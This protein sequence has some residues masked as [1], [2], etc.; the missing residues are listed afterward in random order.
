MVCQVCGAENR[1]DRRFCRECGVSLIAG[2]PS[3]GTVNEPDDR[4][5]GSC[6]TALTGAP[7]TPRPV[8]LQ[9][10][11]TTPRGQGAPIAERRLVTVLFAD[12]VGFTTLAEGRDP[13][14]TRDLLGRYFDLARD[15]AERYGGTVEKFIGDAVMAVWGAPVA[16]ENDPE[17]AVRAALDLLAAIPGLGPGIRAR[18]GLMTG[19]AAV[20][21][22]AIGQGMVAGELVNTAARL[23]AAAAPGEVLV[24]EATMQAAAAAVAFEAAGEQTLKGIAAPVQAWIARRVVAEVGGRNRSEGLEAPFVGRD[25]EIRMLK[26]L[27][28]ATARDGR[29]RLVSVIG[30]AGIGKSRLAWE[31]GKYMD[32]LLQ[33]M[34]WHTGRSPAYGEG[35]TFWALGEM[36]RSRCRL[37]ET[38]DE[39]TTRSKVS[40][41]V[42]R[43]VPDDA[44]RR[45]VTS[46]LLAL[47]GVEEH[48]DDADQLFAAWCAF[49]EHMAAS[50]PVVMVFED[51]HWADSGTL[52]FVDLLL[53]RARAAPIFVLTLARPELLE[54]RPDWGAG[55]R[56]FTSLFL[57]PLPESAMQELIR[58]LAP[59]LPAEARHAIVT[60]ADGVPL[61]AVETVRMLVSDGRLVLRD[62]RYEPNG[63][64]SELAV[65]DSLTA[66]I[67]ARLD[68]LDPMDRSLILDASVLGQSFTPAGLAAVSGTDQAQVVPRLR[69]LVRREILTQLS[70]PRSPELGQFA[71]VQSLIREVAYGTLAHRDRKTRHLAAA[72]WFE[73]LGLDELAGALAGQYLAAHANATDEAEAAA[74]AAQARV[75]LR[76]AADRARILGA[77]DQALAFLR[78]S[79]AVTSDPT[80]AADALDA[81]GE[82]AVHAAR[83]HDAEELLRG[84]LARREAITDRPGALATTSLLATALVSAGRHDEGLE[85]MQ[86]GLERYA[87]L[88]DEPA[89]I[90]LEAQLARVQMLRNDGPASLEVCD[91]VL[92][93]AE[94]IGDV[95]TIADTLVTR[96]SALSL[97]GQTYGGLA[98]LEGG[99]DLAVRQGLRDIELRALNNIAAHGTTGDPRRGMEA[100]KAGLALARR[101]GERANAA[102]LLANAIELAITVG[103]WE[104]AMGEVGALPPPNGT[105]DEWL[106]EFEPSDRALILG[107]AAQLWAFRGAVAADLAEVSE[108]LVASSDP[109]AHRMLSGVL[110]YAAGEPAEARGRFIAVTVTDPLNAP[111]TYIRAARCAIVARHRE[112]ALHDLAAFLDSGVRG[113]AVAAYRTEMEAG[114][115]ALDGRSV[116]ARA[117]FQEVIRMYDELGLPWPAAEAT[118]VMATVLGPTDPAVAGAVIEARTIMRDLGAEPYVRL[119]D[120]LG[121]AP[122]DRHGV[123]TDVAIGAPVPSVASAPDIHASD[124][125]QGRP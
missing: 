84:A 30:P 49:F 69:G 95:R 47:L 10:A 65:P 40:S 62:G 15:V 31:F 35:I 32:G 29:S 6:G 33:T 9:P 90:R 37:L 122:A 2:C 74:L 4:F 115:A 59:G 89:Y 38:D 20:T 94:R 116:D 43:F 106:P 57:E 21:L 63:D 73:S 87:D 12:L 27:Y 23:Q 105:L 113:P 70:D 50:D 77:Y 81:A 80:E 52:D 97:V 100:A 71:F 82:A 109:T 79:L 93:A 7:A 78:Q 61:Y 110:E 123:A 28:H 125:G 75:A 114:I 104:W 45:W 117:G 54:R 111:A 85:I 119:L 118:L 5:C 46:A 64:L 98:A 107:S 112:D 103:D 66:L 8:S 39:A 88:S 72:R 34:W 101:S 48:T 17:R 58:G 53:D 44:D 51:L 124:Q 67:A 18:A 76:A 83:H 25:D 14:E 55:K 121:E 99:R 16:R 91:R 42:E 13:E 11:S 56:Q 36:V 92:A 41:T 3:C 24:G 86:A 68:A 102:F 108:A 120:G 60:R 96:G 1:V 19:E 26:E 22:G